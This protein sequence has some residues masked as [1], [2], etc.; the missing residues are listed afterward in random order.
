M[1]EDSWKQA[2]YYEQ[3]YILKL[4]HMGNTLASISKGISDSY[5]IAH[6]WE[7]VHTLKNYTLFPCF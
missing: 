3:L 7:S 5:L 4:I 2:P 1:P 6:F